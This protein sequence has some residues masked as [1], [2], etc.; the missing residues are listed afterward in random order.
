MVLAGTVTKAGT[1]TEA[2]L[3]ERFTVSP[4]LGAAPFSVTVQASVPDP[5]I[6]ELAQVSALSAFDGCLRFLP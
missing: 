3:L 2:L 5:A 1:V 6:D 4:P